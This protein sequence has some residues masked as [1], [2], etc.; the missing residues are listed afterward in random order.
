[1]LLISGTSRRRL[2]LYRFFFSFESFFSAREKK[3]LQYLHKMRG[4]YSTETVY[5]NFLYQTILSAFVELFDIKLTI[6]CFCVY[7]P[8]FLC[9]YRKC[10]FTTCPYTCKLIFSF[11]KNSLGVITY[12]QIYTQKKKKARKN[13]KLHQPKTKE[14]RYEIKSTIELLENPVLIT[15]YG[16]GFEY[17]PFQ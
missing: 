3:H 1:L 11:W 13:K 16:H 5:C 14:K 8:A 2:K 12:E 17:M 10:F 4:E 9:K 6:Y 15:V 7:S